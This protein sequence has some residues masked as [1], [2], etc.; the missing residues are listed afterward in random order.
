MI[1]LIGWYA[2]AVALLTGITCWF[3]QY[4]PDFLIQK[5]RTDY[6]LRRCLVWIAHAF[7]L[8]VAVLAWSPTISLQEYK[9]LKHCEYSNGANLNCNVP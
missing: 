2:F 4:A 9:P 5:D 8:A 3:G 7:F 1:N 6:K